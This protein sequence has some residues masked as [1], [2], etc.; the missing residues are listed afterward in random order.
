M[1]NLKC[2]MSIFVA[3]ALVLV[4][5]TPVIGGEN[6]AA[7]NK[8]TAI[9]SNST[10]AEMPAQAAQLV[11]EADAKHLKETTIEVVK[12]AVGLNPAAAATIVG[13]IAQTEPSMAATAAAT[14]AGLVPQM[15]AAIARAAA[16][17]APT[18]VGA[19]VEAICRVVPAAYPNVATAVSEVVPGAGKEI[20]T[21]IGAAIPN[22]KGSINQ[23]MA[24]YNN[25]NFPPVP[26]L[27][28]GVANA[29]I[30][31]AQ[32]FVPPPSPAPVLV[33]EGPEGPST[34]PPGTPIGSSP[35]VPP[36]GGV[37]EGNVSP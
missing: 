25:G 10:S 26:F 11:A 8:Y 35:S 31:S 23:T 9:L 2:T 34:G 5:A 22:L 37:G 36:T 27:V 3:A 21:A 28:S 1:K 30:A 13:C 17:V 24:S 19:I 32:P 15:A 33:P 14:A 4:L 18:Q 12:A 29:N 16:A 7:N 20:M 6:K